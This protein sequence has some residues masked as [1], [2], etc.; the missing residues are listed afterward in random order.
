MAKKYQFK[1]T[2]E[3]V[4]SSEGRESTSQPLSFQVGNHD[5]ILQIV[6]RMR[7]GTH[8]DE[9]TATAFAVGLKLLTEVVLENK[10]DPLFAELK[11]AIT[12]FMPKL[13]AGIKER[14]PQQ[15]G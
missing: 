1:I 11:P 10:D 6:Q 14:L 15:Q 2:V 13:K 7:Q 9:N 12:A 4:V 5:D 3:P 8:F